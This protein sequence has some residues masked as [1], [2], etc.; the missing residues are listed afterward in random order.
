MLLNYN[1]NIPNV[2]PR[3]GSGDGSVY[4]NLTITLGGRKAVLIDPRVLDSIKSSI[5][6]IK[7]ITE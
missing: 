7:K 4:A 5:K 6:K 3:V 2:I 1:N